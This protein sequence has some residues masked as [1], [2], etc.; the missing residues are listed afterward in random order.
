M[1][2]MSIIV[3]S[4][5]GNCTACLLNAPHRVCL[6]GVSQ[7]RTERKRASDKSLVENSRELTACIG[8]AAAAP[9]ALVSL[10]GATRLHTS[11]YYKGEQQRSSRRVAP[12]IVVC[13]HSRRHLVASRSVGRSLHTVADWGALSAEWKRQ[14]W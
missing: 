6:L 1:N 13:V 10:I 12:E 11:L 4:I 7:R 5:V 14:V 8:A 3:S 9:V 2:I